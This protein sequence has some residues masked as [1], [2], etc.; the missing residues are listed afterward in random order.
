MSDVRG[1]S[2][3][4]V[5]LWSSADRLIAVRSEAAVSRITRYRYSKKIAHA[6]RCSFWYHIAIGLPVRPRRVS[7]VVPSPSLDLVRGT[8]Y[9]T[10]SLTAHHL[11]LLG[12]IFKL[13]ILPVILE[14]GS[15]AFELCISALVVYRYLLPST[16]LYKIDT[17]CITLH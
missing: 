13:F 9:H 2:C 11:V 8:V 10:S 15:L 17:I 6:A 3:E 12:N 7:L 14:H 16:T 4:F 1:E 5:G